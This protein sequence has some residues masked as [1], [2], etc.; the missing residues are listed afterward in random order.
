MELFCACV[1]LC[2]LYWE[3]WWKPQFLR[4]ST[5]NDFVSCSDWL[6]LFWKGNSCVPSVLFV[7]KHEYVG[8]LG[9]LCFWLSQLETKSWAKAKLNYPRNPV[10]SWFRTYCNTAQS[11]WAFGWGETFPEFL[12]FFKPNFWGANKFWGIT[13]GQLTLDNRGALLSQ[14][15]RAI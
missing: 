1:F 11:K 15:M 9:Q 8:F 13:N 3:S 5:L 14:K 12:V 10:Y 2:S 7:L 4:T 6:L